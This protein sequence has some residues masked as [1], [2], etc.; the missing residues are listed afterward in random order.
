MSD[1]PRTNAAAYP[2]KGDGSDWVSVEFARALER[3]LI[4]A[5]EKAAV[6]EGSAEHLMRV[7]ERLQAELSAKEEICKRLIGL[8]DDQLKLLESARRRNERLQA[9]IDSLMMEYCPEDMTEEQI[10]EWE[11]HQTTVKFPLEKILE[12]ARKS[13]EYWKESFKLEQEANKLLQAA[14][15]QKKEELDSMSK[16]LDALLG[17]VH[18]MMNLKGLSDE[19]L[20]ELMQTAKAVMEKGKE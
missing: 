20:A 13:P 2:R 11:K 1:T 14:Y 17:V 16:T 8:S 19:Q 18:I 4:E 12:E 10:A 15:D 7:N 5:N 9:K 6:W 3:E